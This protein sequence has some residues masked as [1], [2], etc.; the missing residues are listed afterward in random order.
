MKKF[1]KR[2]VAGLMLS[3]SVLSMQANDPNFHI[4]ICLGQSNMEGNAFIEPVDRENVPERFQMMAAVDFNNPQRKQGEW[5]TAVP[6]LVREYT[7]LT[8]MD[9]FGRT[10]VD[11]L[12]E[13]VK[14]G[15]VCV[16]IGGCKIEH[17]DKDFDPA[18][19]V[20][21]ADWFKNFMKAYDNAP[22]ARLVDCAKKAQEAGVI[23]GILL[24]QGCSNNGDP[25]WCNKVH[26]IYDD[27]LSDLEIEPNSIPLLAG[28]V[29]R[30]E[31]GGVCG[32]M[33][34]II[35]T[36]PENLPVAHV[37]SAA[38]LPQKGD[39]LHFT[40]HGYRVLGC[41]YATEM[42]ATMGI[43]DPKVAYSE[44][45]PFVPTPEPSEG[46]FVF[47]F[48]YFNPQ[49]FAN[50]TFDPATG[51][52]KGGQWGFGGWEYQNPIDLSGYKYIVAELSE[53]DKDNAELR[54]FDTASYWEVPYSAKFN[55]GKL[56]VGELDGMMKNLPDGRIEPLNTSEVYR[57]GLWCYGN[58]PIHI[59]HIF[60][61]NEDPYN[62]GALVESQEEEDIPDLSVYNMLG[63]KVA[64]SLSEAAL[65]KGL[66]ICGGKKIF[67]R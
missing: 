51:V 63:A 54:V 50:G 65:S 37:I 17:L 34:S 67:M 55:G 1:L 4:Y 35:S 57:V 42:L 64:E 59:K 26:K 53:D 36:L 47:E 28:E 12:P 21:E 60:T 6:P 19:L 8:P 31:M 16:A 38:N 15:V 62:M 13:D 23:K 61:T 43:N 32:G 48:K 52:F 7:G 44:E 33:N 30:S 41:R 20:K 5:Y 14:V 22:Y 29:V 40:A 9:Y 45:I 2:L 27:L 25:E 3:G 24:H 39:G 11:N 66:Y 10:M 46:D 18:T 49:I 56:I 58:N